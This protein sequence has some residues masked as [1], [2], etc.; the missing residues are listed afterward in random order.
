MKNRKKTGGFKKDTGRLGRDHSYEGDR[1]YGQVPARAQ[2]PL[3]Y[4]SAGATPGKTVSKKK[5]RG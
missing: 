3:T 4:G 2:A 5:R 1:G